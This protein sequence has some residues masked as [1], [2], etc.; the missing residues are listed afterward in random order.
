M[1]FW[2][3]RWH[4]AR[5]KH[6]CEYCG[7]VIEVGER[8]SRET[9]MYAGDFDDYCLCERC[10]NIMP[11]MKV[12][13]IDDTLGEFVDDLIDHDVLDCP[14]CG[15]WNHREYK[16]SEDMMNITLEC[17]KCDH[18]YTVDLSYEAFKEWYERKKQTQKRN[19]T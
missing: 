2:N 5:K 13:A 16:F 15:G 14:K 18:V 12:D 7:K 3:S 19:N 17:D 6:R 10:K 11:Y 4:K 8:Y 1:S 9:G